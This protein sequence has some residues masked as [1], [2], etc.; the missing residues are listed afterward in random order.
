MKAKS[1]D[2]LAEN[3]PTLGLVPDYALCIMHS[4]WN[5][6]R[7]LLDGMDWV[8]ATCCPKRKLVLG[9]RKSAIEGFVVVIT[10]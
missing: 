3:F 5:R 4:T 9:L 10:N 1:L 6:D 7:D 8:P 2:T